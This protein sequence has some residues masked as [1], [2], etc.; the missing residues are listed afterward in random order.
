MLESI[1]NGLGVNGWIA[2]AERSLGLTPHLRFSFEQPFWLWG[3]VLVPFVL[4]LGFSWLRR[5]APWRRGTAAV[6]RTVMLTLLILALARPT[7]WELDERLAVALV[8]DRSDSMSG[9][10][11][12]A[13][14]QWLQEAQAA[15]RPDDRV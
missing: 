13:A 14:D 4:L 3:L 8:V 11:G 12:A 2:W 5:V 7:A 1:W 15:A 10:V 9:V 6:L